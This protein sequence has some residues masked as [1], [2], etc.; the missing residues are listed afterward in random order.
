MKKY[1]SIPFISL[2]FAVFLFSVEEVASQQFTKKKKYWQF[3]GS[4]NTINYVGELDPG[5]TMVSPAV[6]YTKPDIG[7]HIMRK[8]DPRMFWRA[9]FNYGRIKG[10]DNV[11]ASSGESSYRKLRG[12]NFR[13]DVIELKGDVIFELFEN[14]G[15]YTKRSDYN[16]YGF[17]GLA[18]FFHDP[19]TYYNG[20][21]IRTK[22]LH[23]ENKNYSN[24]RQ[25]SN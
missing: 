16:V 5:P 3:G 10:D 23:T 14:R 4:V 15:N 24:L 8:F 17:I 9:S 19:R 12:L 18:F 7:F 22:P 2:L 20:E 1:L 6:R 11:S 25:C 21:W 13:N